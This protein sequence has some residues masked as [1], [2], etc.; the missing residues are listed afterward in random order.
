[1]GVIRT[2]VLV[3]RGGVDTL[4]EEPHAATTTMSDK[5][6]PRRLMPL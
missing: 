3:E 1:V 5:N 6:H 2:D 4:T